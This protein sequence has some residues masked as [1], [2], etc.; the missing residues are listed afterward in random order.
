MK[1]FDEILP[2]KQKTHHFVGKG[3]NSVINFRQFPQDTREQSCSFWGD[4]F[5]PNYICIG[6]Y[7][8]L[9]HE[10]EKASEK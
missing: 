3:L 6:I 4:S 8:Y 1:I 7:R 10:W 2:G 9:S 5:P